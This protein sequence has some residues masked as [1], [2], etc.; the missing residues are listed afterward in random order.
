[1]KPDHWLAIFLLVIVAVTYTELAGPDQCAT[2]DAASRCA[3]KSGTT[4]PKSPAR[5]KP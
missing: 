2:N 5:L 3:G 4:A 1:M